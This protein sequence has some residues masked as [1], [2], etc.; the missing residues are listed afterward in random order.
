MTTSANLIKNTWL[1]TMG[2]QCQ[3]LENASVLIENGRIADFRTGSILVDS[4]TTKVIDGGG[5]VLMPGMVNGHTH[6]YSSL[7]RGMALS[8]LPPHSFPDIL[9]RIWWRLDKALDEDTIHWS[10]MI[11]LIESL[12]QG[13]TTLY[14][15]HASPH[16]VEGSLEIL[17]NAFR[18]IGLRGCLCY[19]VSDREGMEISQKGILENARF[20]EKCRVRNRVIP[21]P[22]IQSL[23]GL[24]ASF[25]LSNATL[26]RVRSCSAHL[27]C[28]FHIH[29]AE[30]RCDVE[31]SLRKY[32]CTIAERLDRFGILGP[33]TLAAHGVHLAAGEYGALA[34]SGTRIVHNPQS[35]TNN[36]VGLADVTALLTAQV[37]VGLGTDGFGP[38]LL[39][40]LRAAFILQKHLHRDPRQAWNEAYQM[41]FVENSQLAT[42]TFGLPVGRIERGAVADLVL[43][44]YVPPTPLTSENFLGHL[45]FGLANAAVDC[46]MVDGK[47][48]V[49]QGRLTQLDETELAAMSREAARRLWTRLEEPEK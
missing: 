48:L 16:C 8:G 13:V 19:E 7:A 43:L 45:Y 23:F 10:A 30:D 14:D 47:W 44:N 40:E 17:E 34:A 38:S 9:E 20:L 37:R 22:Q 49:E 5:R 33:A 42:E 46:V 35:N 27:P 11:G 2:P 4:K 6:L 25:T 41:A 31:D 29:L 21:D 1:L 39:D 3:V 36:A 24:H 32:R 12:K 15:H 18:N 26:E 28:G